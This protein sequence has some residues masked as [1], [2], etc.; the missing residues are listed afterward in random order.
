MIGRFQ[1][2]HNGHLQVIRGVSRQQDEVIIAIGSANESH[3]PRNPFTAGE[4]YH[5]I[6]ASLEAGDIENYSIVPVPDINRYAV[7]VA[8]VESYCPP[9]NGVVTRNPLTATLFGERGYEINEPT[10]VKRSDYSG[11]EIRKRM[12]DGDF[13][14]DLVPPEV[15][16][17]IGV[18][19]GVKRLQSITK[20]EKGAVDDQ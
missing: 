14:E 3:T 8:H 5:M 12:A 1:P 13:W 10:P 20:T 16:D 7:W 19:D 15:V 4:R 18:I 11:T 6:Q 2:F 9:F 17:I